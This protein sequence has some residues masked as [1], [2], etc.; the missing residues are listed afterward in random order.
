MLF[1]L[2]FKL[3]LLNLL[4]FRS[5]QKL[6]FTCIC[7]QKK[8][9]SWI[10]CHFEVEN[11]KQKTAK[12]YNG[13]LAQEEARLGDGLLQSVRLEAVRQLRARDGE[14]G[15]PPPL[16]AHVLLLRGIHVRHGTRQ[17]IMSLL[18]RIPTS[19][20]TPDLYCAGP[21]NG[22]DYVNLVFHLRIFLPMFLFPAPN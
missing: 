5:K 6:F 19:F 22:A 17:A 9:H 8:H 14:H 20:Q 2:G 13:D 18:V 1:S 10:K 4:S 7:L 3:N 15:R 21:G 11:P 16:L 12:C